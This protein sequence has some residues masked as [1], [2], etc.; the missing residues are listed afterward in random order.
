MT[1]S[2][3]WRRRRRCNAI[4]REDDAPCDLARERGMLA[5]AG[6]S[7]GLERAP[8]VLGG[9]ERQLDLG[10]GRRHRDPIARRPAR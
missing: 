6:R 1:G 4:A 7:G 8:G 5:N 9:I 10:L 3:A 2:D